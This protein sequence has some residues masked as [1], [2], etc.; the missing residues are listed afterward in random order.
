MEII[1]VLDMWWPLFKS[2]VSYLVNRRARYIRTDW[3]FW[4]FISS[5]FFLKILMTIEKTK[6]S[7]IPIRN[8]F[9][10]LQ[11]VKYFR[12]LWQKQNDQHE[13][14]FSNYVRIQDV[15]LKTCLRRWT[16][17]KSVERGSGIS[18]LPARHDDD[19]IYIYSGQG[20]LSFTWHKCQL[21]YGKIRLICLV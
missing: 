17:G 20:R 4:V 21:S 19:D 18:V 16:T 13:H 14:T 8:H 7:F 10:D 1:Y 2:F 9:S 12:F 11:I 15:A 3:H 5:V 6:R